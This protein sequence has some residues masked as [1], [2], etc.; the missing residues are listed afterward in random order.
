MNHNIRTLFIAL[1]LLAF[2]SEPPSPYADSL[3]SL[4]SEQKRTIALLDTLWAD[5]ERES[6]MAKIDS[7]LPVAS[8]DEAARF[9]LELLHRQGGHFIA[10]GRPAAAEPPLR[11]A[12]ALSESLEDS[13]SLRAT[14]RWHSVA[15][16]RSGEFAEAR[17]LFERLRDLSFS[18]S[19]KRHEG[20]A[21]VGIGWLE[22][23]GGRETNA[24]EAYQR[25]ALLL[26]EVGDEEGG[27]WANTALGRTLSNY[28]QP[29]KALKSF[30]RSLEIARESG[31]TVSEAQ[32][33]NNIAGLEYQLGD[34]QLALESF[35]QAYEITQ[36]TK[37]LRATVVPRINI[38]LCYTDLGRF[39]EAEE[40]LQGSLQICRDNGFRDLEAEVLD[41][42]AFLS[43][44]QDRH[45]DEVARC[46]EILELGDHLDFE[47]R[48]NGLLRLASALG[49]TGDYESALEKSKEAIALLGSRRSHRLWP[50]AN[51]QLG[52]DLAEVGRLEEGLEHTM[53]GAAAAR[54]QGQSFAHIEGLF[55]AARM[56]RELGRRDLAASILDEASTAW[57]SRRA[58]SHNP[59][60]R[61]ERGTQGL[62]LYSE[63]AALLLTDS[64]SLTQDRLREAYDRLQVFKARTLQERMLGV[65][66]KSDSLSEALSAATVADL[67]RRVLKPGEI[68]LDAYLGSSE[69]HLFAVTRDTCVVATLKSGREL[70]ASVRRYRGLLSQP[71]DRSDS[72]DPDVLTAVAEQIRSLLFP[73][74]AELLKAG[75]HVIVCPDGGLNLMPFA[76]LQ[77]EGG[78]HDNEWT[79]IPSATILTWLRSDERPV[80][81][82]T[83]PGGVLAIAATEGADG[84][85]LEGAVAEVRA[86]GRIYGQVTT[87]IVS[88]TDAPPQPSDLETA[89]LLHI[90]AHADLNNQRPWQSKIR[91]GPA[92]SDAAISAEEVAELD[93][94]ADLAVL[95]SCASAGGRILNCEGVLGLSSAFLS[96]GVPAVVATLWSVDDATTATFMGHFYDALEEGETVAGAVAH[97]QHLVRQDPETT[98][99]FFWAGFIVV[100]DGD[101]N[102]TLE[103]RAPLRGW[104]VVGLVI[105]VMTVLLTI[106]RYR[107]GRPLGT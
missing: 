24:I 89:S 43:T 97:A 99:P 34:P 45:H 95:S 56:A 87:Q 77:N 7:L 94:K 8:V 50:L 51:S 83:S 69:S 11:E 67:Q 76:A 63:L 3:D 46:L 85:P 73:G 100:G 19:D 103:R 64:A 62:K 55:S 39:D 36:R 72:E 96:A 57:E 35:Q 61:E 44:K 10:L 28:G 48:L 20:W 84:R 33:L 98:E 23:R 82:D 13:A 107:I 75:S 14:M 68:L 37:D 29:R 42:L 49:N 41:K 91:F 79:R 70:N 17:M 5:G 27:W 86:L 93:L 81:D 1:L 16:G 25:A 15:L 90:A 65:A 52:E 22:A 53:T 59:E 40:I 106:M 58:L 18:A 4:T 21:L 74:L 26:E 6:T 105:A 88:P 12:V 47:E 30:R 71:P 31:R 92:H 32:S 54:D 80:G 66:G 102:V 2:L 78:V 9:R 104:M 38:S 101:V 60:W